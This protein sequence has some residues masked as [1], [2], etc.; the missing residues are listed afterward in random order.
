M[1]ERLK[2]N[3]FLIVRIIMIAGF[4][5]CGFVEIEDYETGVSVLILLLVSFYIG[6]MATKELFHGWPKLAMA[7]VGVVLNALLVYFGGREFLLLGRGIVCRERERS[8]GGKEQGENKQNT[9]NLF[10]GTLPGFIN[11][12]KHNA[13][14]LRYIAES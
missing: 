1:G 13:L 12:I 2:N 4:S 3:Y 14:A 9:E 10:H 11:D 5:V 8:R 6:V 7:L